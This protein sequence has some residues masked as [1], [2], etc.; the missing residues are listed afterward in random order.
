[1]SENRVRKKVTSYEAIPI[2]AKLK[3]FFKHLSVVKFILFLPFYLPGIILF[4]LIYLLYKLF[5]FVFHYPIQCYNNYMHK[6]YQYKISQWR[7]DNSNIFIYPY[8]QLWNSS[9]KF[10]FFIPIYIII[11]PFLM[12]TNFLHEG[13]K[14]LDKKLERKLFMR[15]KE[16]N[17]SKSILEIVKRMSSREEPKGFRIITK[18]SKNPELLEYIN[19]R[20]DVLSR[21][22]P[23]KQDHCIKRISETKETINDKEEERKLS[24]D[25]K[26]KSNI[27]RNIR[28]LKR[29]VKEIEE[30]Y[31]MYRD[32]LKS[33]QKTKQRLIKKIAVI[34]RT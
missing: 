17:R 14:R 27:S 22:M 4:I 13:E 3:E 34:K 1:M 33:L 18:K 23:D 2:F 21:R 7:I 31:I 6:A 9:I 25:T 11:S 16:P 19:E 8:L 10:P 12:L 32:M 24:Q 5:T 30:D 15:E 26:E 28:L 20:I 29:K